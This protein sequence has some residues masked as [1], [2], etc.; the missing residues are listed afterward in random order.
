MDQS[1]LKVIDLEKK[2]SPRRNFIHM[3]QLTLLKG[4]ESS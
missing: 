3:R 1:E 4:D 2:S